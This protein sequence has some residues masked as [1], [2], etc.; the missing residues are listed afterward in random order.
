MKTIAVLIP[1]YNEE[2]T[3]GEVVSN[4]RKH[5]PKSVIYVYDNCS[6][7][8][9]AEVARA[10]GAVVVSALDRGKGN[11]V[12]KMFAD[13]EA[14]IFLMVDGDSTYD[15]SIAPRMAQLLESSGVDM[16]V[17]VRKENSA[18]A[19]PSGHKFGNKIFNLILRMFFHSTFHDIFS[20]YRAFSKRFV[21]TFPAMTSGFDIE[22]EMSIHTLMLSIPFAEIESI[23]Q[24]RPSN[25]HSKLRTF[26]DGTK[27]LFRIISLL[28][29]TR[30]LFFFGLISLIL[31]S[32]AMLIAYPL[33]ITFLET[34]LVP[35]LPTAVLS[36]G[37]M[38]MAF[39]SFACGM[40]LD[41]IS[42]VHSEMK[43]LHYLS[44]S[45][46]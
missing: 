13:V 24:E 11:V 27:I 25:S 6:E 33:I 34:G 40:I 9:T 35:R 17:A 7:D 37:I 36:V 29:E 18:G 10:A 23:Y 42:R 2:N 26:V 5:L 22:V 43:K 46:E 3:I 28:K 21:K 4:F 16:V 1:C 39:I 20:G 14:D 12:R 8:T 31:S 30:P 44:M 15:A 41:G 32:A 38:M 45:R 19:Y